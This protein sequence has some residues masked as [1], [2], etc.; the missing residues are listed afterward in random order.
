M[1]R[2]KLVRTYERHLRTPESQERGTRHWSRVELLDTAWFVVN[3][4]IDQGADKGRII[5]TFVAPD[6]QEAI[7]ICKDMPSTDW[8]Q[9]HAFVRAPMLFPAGFVFDTVDQ[10]TRLS[11]SGDMLLRFRSG[12]SLHINQSL[13]EDQTQS[14]GCRQ[15]YP[16]IVPNQ[17]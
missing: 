17:Y 14:E 4:C 1:D 5:R 13:A 15:I 16:L 2:S 12:L 10:A 8:V 3:A 11:E 6:F 7:A 9:I